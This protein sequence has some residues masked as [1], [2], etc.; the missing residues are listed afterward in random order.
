[1][2][3]SRGPLCCSELDLVHCASTIIPKQFLKLVFYLLFQ[4]PFEENMFQSLFYPLQTKFLDTV[5]TLCGRIPQVFLKQIEKTMRVV[6]EKKVVR[7]VRLPHEKWASAAFQ[8]HK[9]ESLPA[10]WIKVF[11]FSVFI[12]DEQCQ[13]QA[14]FGPL[15]P[16]WAS[17]VSGVGDLSRNKKKF[18]SAGGR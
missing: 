10:S 14:T 2:V 9:E 6:Y 3:E 4:Y 13:K 15:G 5:N 7:H 12:E 11:L 1:M 16:V 18:W 17:W 8:H